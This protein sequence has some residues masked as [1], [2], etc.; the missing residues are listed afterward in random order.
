LFRVKNCL[1]FDEIIPKIRKLPIVRQTANQIIDGIS[2][3]Y[4]NIL[5]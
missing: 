1:I 2:V 3:V 4:Q 5:L